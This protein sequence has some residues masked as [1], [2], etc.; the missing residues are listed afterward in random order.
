EFLQLGIQ[1]VRVPEFEGIPR[2]KNGRMTKLD[3]L[4]MQMHMGTQSNIDEMNRSF[5][6]SESTM[7]SVLRREL[8]Q[9][10]FDFVQNG[11]WNVFNSFVPRIAALEKMTKGIDA[12]FI[13]H[14][15]FT[16]FG[17]EYP[18]GYMPIK[19]MFDG[20]AETVSAQAEHDVKV[21]KGEIPEEQM[22]GYGYDGIVRSPF[23]K[24]RTGSDLAINIAPE[25]LAASFNEVIYDLTMRVPVRDVTQILAN[26]SVSHDL[27]SILGVR[28]LEFLKAAVDEMT[29]SRTAEDIMKFGAWQSM[30]NNAMSN[31]QGAFI[32][33]QLLGNITT[34]AIQGAAMRNALQKMGVASGTKH[35]GFAI[36]KIVSPNNW[37]RMKETFQW[38]AELDPSIET[39]RQSIDDRTHDA[40]AAKLPKKRVIASKSWNFVRRFQEGA[41]EAFFRGVLGNVDI[42]MKM[43][44]AIA[45][46]N[47]FMAGEAQGYGLDVLAKMSDD[48]RHR[49]AKAYVAE[50]S[51]TSLTSGTDLD[52]AAIQKIPLGKP[53]AMFFN[54]A[55]NSLNSNMQ[56]LRNV[57]YDLKKAI[58]AG[59]NGNFAEANLHFSGA[60]D[61]AARMLFLSATG[62]LIVAALRGKNPVKEE[63]EEELTMSETLGRVPGYIADKMTSPYDL[64]V[65]MFGQHVPLLRSMIYAGQYTS[66][67]G[68]A[69]VKE[70][71]AAILSDATTSA[72]TL[73]QM[74]NAW[75]EGATWFE[76]SQSLSDQQ[77]KAVGSTLSAFVGG[78]GTNAM[79]KYYRVLRDNEDSPASALPSDLAALALGAIGLL[80][81]NETDDERLKRLEEETAQDEVNAM[82][83]Q[84]EDFRQTF[85][86]DRLAGTDPLSDEQYEQ[87]MYTESG[88][89]SNARTGWET[90]ENGN[91]VEDRYGNRKRLSNAYGPYQFVPGTWRAMMEKYPELGLTME[92][93]E[94][95]DLEQHELAMRQLTIE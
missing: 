49:A 88:G 92:G 7:R 77:M 74:Y 71:M 45:G 57:N 31:V 60:G 23:T 82:K 80:L 32:V 14:K 75:H 25:T 76:A 13:E 11:V 64:F 38:A 40:I 41:N 69:T 72:A 89:D 61:R 47:Q 59:K 87:I 70:P 5:G 79:F 91:I 63:D 27:A 33:N 62:M 16:E 26:K 4:M 17:K 93:Y 68:V 1:K 6:V 95:P 58:D 84:A 24:E 83:N 19:R 35:L 78:I 67:Q 56:E 85:A 53:I 46:Y 12:K 66:R 9:K 10:D 73:P 39:A 36:A 15:G 3:L 54:D 8:S 43:S 2:L 21:A 81:G 22:R 42:L 94:A 20:D 90:D 18:G 34:I 86:A 55:R 52:R 28:R 51:F 50:L 65:E 48:E 29:K 44:T 30:L 37:T